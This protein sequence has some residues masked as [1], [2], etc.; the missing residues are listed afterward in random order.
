MALTALPATLAGAAI[1]FWADTLP[2]CEITVHERLAAPDQS[3]DLV[4]FSRKCGA[5][6]AP[7]T[8]AALIPTGENLLEDAA[9]FVSVAA[10]ADLEPRWRNAGTIEMSLPEKDEVLR[11][12]SSV[13]GVT[14][15]Y[16]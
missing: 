3:Y 13:V 7:N 8:Q 16:R 11:Q 14:V 2:G 4:V 6:S 12:D 5:S 9:S 10:E 15:V 1:W